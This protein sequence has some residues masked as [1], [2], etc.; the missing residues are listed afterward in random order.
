[1]YEIAAIVAIFVFCYSIL[2][3]RL[4]KTVVGGAITFTVVGLMLGS[5][6]LGVLDLKIGLSG[7]SVLA[8]LTLAFLLFAD[9]ANVD[10]RELVRSSAL[11]RRLLLISLP[12]TILLGTLT[13]LLFIDNITLIEI[14]LLATILAPTDAALGKAVVTNE[15][16]PN[17]IRTSLNFESGLNDGICVPIFLAFLAFATNSAGQQS[18]GEIAS[19]LIVEEIG[20]GVLVGLGIVSIGIGG[21]IVTGVLKTI[22]PTWSLLPVPAL[23]LA[24]FCS[25]QALGGSGFVAAFVGGLLFGGLVE[26][27]RKHSLIMAAEGIG[28]LAALL[29]WVV[30]GATVV[31]RMIDQVTWTMVLYALL[32]LTLVRMLPVWLSLRGL[33]IRY[34][35]ALFIGWFGPRGLASIV[36]AVMAVDAGIPGADLISVVVACT[37]LSSVIA[38]G[39]SANPLAR[40][41]SSRLSATE[42][43]DAKE[44]QKT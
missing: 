33:G 10:L 39:L 42:I 29:T 23:A 28:D 17:R 2:A 40:L 24:C 35:E 8:E 41:L 31:G 4:E 15:S 20:I 19:H 38:H 22:S 26:H 13:G 44:R 5:H 1:M 9:A 7:L 43:P 21:A 37:I 25:A 6:G 18:F 11:P 36:F 30:F 16:V 34:D 14:A 3:D 27:E 32:S 12:L